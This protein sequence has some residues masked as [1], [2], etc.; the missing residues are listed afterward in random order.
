MRR[1][2]FFESAKSGWVLT[3]P[4]AFFA[5]SREAIVREQ[6]CSLARRREGAK[7]VKVFAVPFALS[8]LTVLELRP[9]GP[10]FFA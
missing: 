8:H 5:S 6:R 9:K 10:S 4:F 7:L 2:K 3:A 1:T